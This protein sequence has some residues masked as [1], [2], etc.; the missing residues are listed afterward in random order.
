MNRI[1]NDEKVDNYNFDSYTFKK[2]IKSKIDSIS[3]SKEFLNFISALIFV[4][5]LIGLDYCFGLLSEYLGLFV[6][7]NYSIIATVFICG[8]ILLAP[9]IAVPF[10]IYKF[11]MAVKNNYLYEKARYKERQKLRLKLM[12]GNDLLEK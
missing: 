11:I 12:K 3:E 6:T 2:Y 5:F 4:L 8:F 7:A 10:I 1:E 9:V